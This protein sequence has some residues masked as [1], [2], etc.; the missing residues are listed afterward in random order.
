MLLAKEVSFREAVTSAPSRISVRLKSAVCQK[1]SAI[2]YVASLWLCQ[3]SDGGGSFLP[4]QSCPSKDPN[5][6]E[7]ISEEN[8]VTMLFLQVE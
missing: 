2:A 3:A 8:A 1:S 6:A 5:L 4:C 7:K